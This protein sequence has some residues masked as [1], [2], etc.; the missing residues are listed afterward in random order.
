MLQVNYRGYLW[1]VISYI[2]GT[3]YLVASK[4]VLNNVEQL[5]FLFWWY[6]SG[7]FYHSLHIVN[8]RITHKRIF[9][10]DVLKENR[11]ILILYVILDVTATFSFFTAINM[12]DPSIV[13][14]LMQAQ[15]IFTVIL[16][17]LFLKEILCRTELIAAAVIICGLI[18][19]TYRSGSVPP[20]GVFLVLFANLLASFNLIIV[21]KIGVRVGAYT[22]A[23]I[24]TISVFLF[25]LIMNLVYY[26]GVSVPPAQYL[27]IIL[28]GAFFG[29]YLNVVSIYKT[30]EYIPA[31]KTALFRSLQPVFIMGASV[32]ILK[33]FPGIKETIGGI[34]IVSG[35][36]LLFYSNA[37]KLEDIRN[38]IRSL[39][40]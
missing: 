25:F 40:E 33:T 36:I 3:I 27:I 2:C 14:F 5:T 21:K 31:A 18:V 20:F 1:L 23:R 24:R 4:Y 17:Y 34:I 39:R 6:T 30:L 8:D 26:G 11:K 37:D 35:N 9:L 38:F 29:P 16:G 15:V 32:M 7:I 12:L 10:R 28:L 19:M 13:S 22:I